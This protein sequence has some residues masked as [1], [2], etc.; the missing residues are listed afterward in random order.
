MLARR[1]HQN[2][3]HETN[4][5][6]N[7]QS[8]KFVTFRSICALVTFDLCTLSILHNACCCSFAHSHFRYHNSM[9]Y[10]MKAKIHCSIFIDVLAVLM[11]FFQFS[12]ISQCLLVL[13]LC[14]LFSLLLGTFHEANIAFNVTTI[15][16]INQKYQR[17]RCTQLEWNITGTLFNIH[18]QISHVGWVFIKTTE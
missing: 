12:N 5:S 10:L 15:T 11:I 3:L 14:I 13:I 9:W 8:I 2:A 7:S 16:T 1:I 18:Q 4:A 17:E 6:L